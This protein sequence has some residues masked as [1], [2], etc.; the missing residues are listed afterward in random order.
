MTRR[1]S[2]YASWNN[3]FYRRIFFSL[4]RDEMTRVRDGGTRRSRS[5]LVISNL[6]FRRV[7]NVNGVA[8]TGPVVISV[9]FVLRALDRP[10][11]FFG[12]RV[13]PRIY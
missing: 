13:Q 8:T 10:Y 4:Y 5:S 7:V 11:L 3:K 6:L 9:S 2:A 12:S 1:R